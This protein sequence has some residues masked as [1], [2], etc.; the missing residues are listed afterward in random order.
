M[1]ILE[2]ENL[3]QSMI[4][5][6][7]SLD[8]D[9]GVRIS[10]PTEG[11]PAWKITEDITFLQVK[12]VDHPYN[13]QRERQHTFIASPD[14]LT[15]GVSY[16]RVVSVNCIMYGPNS[17]ANA[18][19]LR[20][21]MFEDSNRNTLREN[22]LY[23]IPDIVEPNRVPELFEGRWWERSDITLL[24]NEFVTKTSTDYYLKSATVIVKTEDGITE[25]VE[26]TQ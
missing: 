18:Q 7:L 16:T 4:A 2:L 10:W 21:S 15:T 8:A 23:L 26:I 17:F 14:S 25:E 22:N 20:D 19:L 5:E 12:T 1:E 3:F 11:A 9:S 24:F 13:R 6:T